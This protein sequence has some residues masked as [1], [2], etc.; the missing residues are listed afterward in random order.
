MI[1]RALVVV[2]PIAGPGAAQRRLPRLEAGLRERGLALTVV[3]TRAAGGARAATRELAPDHDLVVVVG[4]DGTLNEVINGLEAD[5]SV[6]LFPV[7]TGNVVAKELRLPR[8]IGPFCRMLGAGRERALD[9]GSAG[10]RRFLAFVGAGF[11]AAVARR[12][13]ER[14]AGGTRMADYA[15]LIVRTLADYD[16]PRITVAVDGAEPVASGGF[17]LVSNVR[18]YGGPFVLT[19]R[20]RCDDGQLDVCVLPRAGRARYVWTTLGLLA[21]LPPA[22]MGARQLRGQRV[23]LEADD[24]V[25]YQVD[26]DPAGTLPVE[27]RVLD[28]KARFIVP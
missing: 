24:Q 15:G 20:A 13:A 18:S 3:A 4:G 11:D 17:A 14:R 28:R 6:A 9:V 22:L 25:P 26:G 7:G 10:G 27:V 12:M 2:N 19:P 1:R 5:V 23:R 16:F 21:H 8:R